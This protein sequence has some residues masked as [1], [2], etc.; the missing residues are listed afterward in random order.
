MVCQGY[1]GV[2]RLSSLLLLWHLTIA[3]SLVSWDKPVL[4]R[5]IPYLPWKISCGGSSTSSP[6]Y[7]S[8]PARK[9]L[10]KAKHDFLAVPKATRLTVQV[11]TICL[12]LLGGFLLV[13]VFFP[14]RLP[15]L[16]ME[17]LIK[18]GS[19]L[20]SSPCLVLLSPAQGMNWRLEGAHLY[21]TP[22]HH[23]VPS[24]YIPPDLKHFLVLPNSHLL[25]SFAPWPDLCCSITEVLWWAA[26]SS[27][28][29]LINFPSQPGIIPQD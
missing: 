29:G 6:I 22:T 3:Y 2:Y 5:C 9:D 23:Y 19:D 20:L 21:T 25:V 8:S 13:W 15:H 14:Q 17:I 18:S 16:K 1:L 28:K 24:W 26:K 27:T 4:D 12:L 7:P 11:S 10:T